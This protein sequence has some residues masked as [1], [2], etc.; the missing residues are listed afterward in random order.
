MKCAKSS[1]NNECT[2]YEL[3]DINNEMV[4]FFFVAFLVHKRKK[5]WNHLRTT[6]LNVT[7]RGSKSQTK[8][9]CVCLVQ[10][11][12]E[13]RFRSF[14]FSSHP[15]KEEEELTLIESNVEMILI[16]AKEKW[17]KRSPNYCRCRRWECAFDKES[18]IILL[19]HQMITFIS[20]IS[21]STSTISAFELQIFAQNLSD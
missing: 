11:R 5:N 6:I 3:V 16:A 1:S 18:E 4:F 13:I 17:V 8:L 12:I 14:L 2:A 9:L 10:F 21:P 15:E 7:A 20:S 19:L